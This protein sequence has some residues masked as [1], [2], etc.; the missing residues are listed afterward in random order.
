MIC[1]RDDGSGISE[2]NVEAI[3][4]RLAEGGRSERVG[5]YSVYNRLRI[6]MGGQSRMDVSRPENGGAE[7]TI[8]WLTDGDM[9]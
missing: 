9:L 3:Q 6:C 5:L 1:V 8:S 7:I 4:K 2:E